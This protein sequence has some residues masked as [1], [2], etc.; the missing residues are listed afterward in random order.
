M[1]HTSSLSL[2][3]L[4]LRVRKKLKVKPV[5]NTEDKIVY[6]F[7]L[8]HIRGAKRYINDIIEAESLPLKVKYKLRVGRFK[9]VILIQP[10]ENDK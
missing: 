10:I 4:F 9:D 6:R 1:T 2:D 7:P 8:F 3:I 5:I